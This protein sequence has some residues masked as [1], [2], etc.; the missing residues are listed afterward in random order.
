MRLST[1]LSILCLGLTLGGTLCPASAAEDEQAYGAQLQGFE[2]PWPVAHFAFTSQGEALD[3][4]YMDVKPTA[5]AANGETVVLLH[6]KN[7]CAATWQDTIAALTAGGYRVIAPDQIGFCKSTKPSHYQ[8]TL[9]QLA[10]NTRALLASLGIDHVTIIGHSLGGM[11][12]M[13]YALT[14]PADV[15][16]LI[17]VDP[18]GLEDWKAKGVPWQ[19]VD[20]WYQQELKTTAA[21][22]RDY[23]RATYYAGTW[24]EKYERWVQMLAG[25]Y[26]GPGRE[27]VAW[28]AAL[29]DDMA[30]TQPVYYEFEHISPPV[31]LMVGDKDTTA[32]GKNLAPPAVRATLGNYPVLAK[33]A[34][35]RMPHA[36]L[37]EFPEFGHSPQIQA[38]AIF[39]KALFGFLGK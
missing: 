3:M 25:L 1:I 23:Q 18:I 28:N 10:G 13:R 12:G 27:I 19:S 33:S 16:L 9:Q 17:L 38:P 36:Q 5:G 2:Y 39:H 32:V 8:Y 29:I 34:V 11:L 31:R 21:S 20:A 4:A 22:I 30:F 14:F 26:R 7:F 37:I 35:A 6:G 15:K 24:D